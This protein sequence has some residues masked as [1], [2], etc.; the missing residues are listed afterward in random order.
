MEASKST[1]QRANPMP[2]NPEA[3]PAWLTTKQV[4]AR[5][6]ISSSTVLR[7][8]DAGRLPGAINVGRG[9]VRRRGLRIPEAAVM[10]LEGSSPGR[11]AA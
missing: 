9:T 4:A 2:Q 6:Y 11:E 3:A 10:A 5:L 1:D 7:L 8:V